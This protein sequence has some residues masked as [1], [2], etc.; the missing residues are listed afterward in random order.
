MSASGSRKEDES[1]GARHEGVARRGTDF[2]LSVLTLLSVV[3]Y[4]PV[5]RLIPS[6]L[7]DG[8]PAGFFWLAPMAWM[9]MG[10]CA[11]LVWCWRGGATRRG[12]LV[13]GVL[14]TLGLL[15]APTSC[16]YAAMAVH[17]GPPIPR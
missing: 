17:E 8:N 10:I 15:G 9:I 13:W 4:W 1:K 5:L 14:V 6:I 11:A 3:V 7:R 12:R 16:L 2:F